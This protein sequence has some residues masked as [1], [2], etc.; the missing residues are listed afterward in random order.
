L[1]TY[2]ALTGSKNQMFGIFISYRRVDTEPWAGRLF[3]ELRRRFGHLEVFMDIKECVP[4]GANYETKIREALASCNVL[5]ALIG[6]KWLTCMQDNIRRLDNPNDWVRTEIISA[7]QRNIP[8]VPLLLG[9]AQI[10]SEKELPE[11]LRSLELQKHEVAKL[12][13]EEFDEDFEKLV[14]DLTRQTSL[15][16]VGQLH[17]PETAIIR[18]RELIHRSPVVTDG[19]ITSREALKSAREQVRELEF[20]KTVHDLLHQIEFDVQRPIQESGANDGKLGR[21]KI[22]FQNF[23]RNILI[24]TEGREVPGT[25]SSLVEALQ[26]TEEAFNEAGD[27]LNQDAYDSLIDALKGLLHFSDFL[28]GAISDSERK[29]HLEA[30]TKT[31]STLRPLMPVNDLEDLDLQSAIRDFSQSL[32]FLNRMQQELETR[33]REHRQFQAL[34]SLLR[35][36]CDGPAAKPARQWQRV[37]Q[38]RSMLLVPLPQAWQDNELENTGALIESAVQDGREG[39]ARDL[40]NQY[41]SDVGSVFFFVDTDLKKLISR[42]ATINPMLDALID[43]PARGDGL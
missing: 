5:I 40:L 37:K 25:R 14:K 7:L 28:D 41:L 27:K 6:P 36:I 30:V 22:K 9:G 4:R 23:R 17:H 19:W 3:T 33:V 38:S 15:H 24:E 39:D 21:Y 26:V 12:R 2:L 32:V 16:D 42:L 43:G 1:F 34:C 18:L 20:Y 10:P 8:V 13:E 35:T 31:M 29:L 11:P